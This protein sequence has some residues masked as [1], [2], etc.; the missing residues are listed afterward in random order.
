MKRRDSTRSVHLTYLLLTR[1]RHRETKW[2]DRRNEGGTTGVT[3]G[4]TRVERGRRPVS[5]SLL[6]VCDG[7]SPALRASHTR[8]E[9]RT[10]D[11]P[12][13]TVIPSHFRSPCPSGAV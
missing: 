13:L 2:S 4:V 8:Y 5:L 6:S 1:R 12:R 10:R 9:K 11:T 7:R 3:T